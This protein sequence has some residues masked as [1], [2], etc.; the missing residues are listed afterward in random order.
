MEQHEALQIQYEKLIEIGLH[1]D[2]KLWLI[3]S[4]AYSLLAVSYYGIFS[5]EVSP[6]FRIAFHFLP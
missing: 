1:Y 6:K 3:P 5:S 4:A 2:Q